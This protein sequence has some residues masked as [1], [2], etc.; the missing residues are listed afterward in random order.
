MNNTGTNIDHFCSTVYV[1]IDVHK[2]TYT[3]TAL[4]DGVILKRATVRAHPQEFTKN[5]KRWFSNKKIKTVY[6]AGFSGHKLHRCL[7]ASGI[8][9]KVINPAS[10]EISSKDKVKTDKKD[11]KKLAEQLSFNRL[12]G[13]CVPSLEVEFKRCITRGREQ[14][15]KDRIRCGNQIKSCLHKFGYISCD[16]DRIMSEKLLKYYE[17]FQFPEPLKFHLGQLIK[18]WRFISSQIKEYESQ[19]RVQ[20]VEDSEV[21]R[22]YR[23]VPGIGY[24]SAR[25]L[26]NELGD[27]SKRFPTAKGLYQFVGL[28]PSE[29]SSGDKVIRGRIDRQGSGRL[30]RVLVEASWV[31]IKKDIA[32]AVFFERLAVRRGKKRAIVAVARKLLGRCHHCFVHKTEYVLGVVE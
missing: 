20:A 11:S 21:D 28:T 9:N 25:I 16:D 8:E 31:A 1:G 17:N 6:E 10:I 29:H 3:F 32:L 22:I 13:N 12:K 26:A 23:S 27:V 15:L 19:F 18:K 24:L 2:K 5:L 7:I 14:L 4:E 30:R